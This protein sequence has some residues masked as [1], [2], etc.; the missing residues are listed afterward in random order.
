V[1]VQA[2]PSP[3]NSPILGVSGQDSQQMPGE[4]RQRRENL[5]VIFL[6]DLSMEL[7]MIRRVLE[8]VNFDC[9]GML[10]LDH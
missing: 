9:S 1:G 6:F 2:L 10:L 7:D 5:T 3:L 4:R 8:L